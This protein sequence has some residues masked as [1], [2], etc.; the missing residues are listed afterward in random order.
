M[1]FTTLFEIGASTNI[2]CGIPMVETVGTTT[3]WRLSVS[4]NRSYTEH[5]ITTETEIIPVDIAPKTRLIG[6]FKWTE[7]NVSNL[8]FEADM[9]V[10]F[11]DDSVHT[12]NFSGMFNEVTNTNF[13]GMY[14]EEKLAEG[15]RCVGNESNDI[16][17]YSD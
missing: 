8:P 13:E 7:G 3:N 1:G 14:S 9:R 11:N 15:E 5:N 17:E 10:V 4:H 16:G 12:F 6:Q 2:T